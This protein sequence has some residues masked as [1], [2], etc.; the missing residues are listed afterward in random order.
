MA[1]G[2]YEP[3]MKPMTDSRRGSYIRERRGYVSPKASLTVEQPKDT[4]SIGIPCSKRGHV[5]LS[6]LSYDGS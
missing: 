5:E 4:A 3:K 1:V 6:W 2:G